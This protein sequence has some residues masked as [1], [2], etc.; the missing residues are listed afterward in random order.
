MTT[1]E[2][3]AEFNRFC[4]TWGIQTDRPEFHDFVKRVCP[5]QRGAGD[6]SWALA[7]WWNGWLHDA[8][9]QAEDAADERETCAAACDRWDDGQGIR[10]DPHID[11]F[12]G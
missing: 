8:I 11:A 7:R 3:A 10:H 2:Q 4:T 5:G 9:V 12:I 1:A 6:L